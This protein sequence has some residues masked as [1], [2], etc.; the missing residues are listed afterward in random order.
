MAE[1]DLCC[2]DLQSAVDGEDH[3]TLFFSDE[4]VLCLAT[5]FEESEDGP[6]WYDTPIKFCPFCGSDITEAQI[7]V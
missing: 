7:S 6:V 5:G 3:P 1:L 4:R 2:E